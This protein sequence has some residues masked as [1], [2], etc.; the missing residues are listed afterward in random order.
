MPV[1]TGSCTDAPIQSNSLMITTVKDLHHIRSG[2]AVGY[3][4]AYAGATGTPVWSLV[5]GNLP[6][7]LSLD[8]A[9]GTINNFKVFNHNPISVN[10]VIA[11][12]VYTFT[13]KLTVGS[14]FTTKQFSIEVLPDS[15]KRPL[16]YPQ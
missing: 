7:T 1:L 2:S 5:S 15:D 10:N 9:S 6:P 13:V 11:P 4:L 16:I 3:T 8:T 14:E 12:G